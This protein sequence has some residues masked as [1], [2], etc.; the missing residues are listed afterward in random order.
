MTGIADV[1]WLVTT[2]LLWEDAT[3]TIEAKFE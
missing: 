1:K 2:P 3:P